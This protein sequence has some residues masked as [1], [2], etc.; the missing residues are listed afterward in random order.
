MKA[1]IFFTF[2]YLFLIVVLLLLSCNGENGQLSGQNIRYPIDSTG[3]ATEAWQMDSLMALINQKY[4]RERN[5]ILFVQNIEKTENWRIAICPHDDYAYA[6]ELYPYVLE[7]LKTPTVIIF[8]VAHKAAQ[9]GIEDHLVFDSFSHWQGPYGPVPVSKLRENLLSRLP[10][11]QYIIH[12]SLQQNEH[13]VEALIPFL[14]YYQPAVE[15]IPIL[16]P[17]MNFDRMEKISGTLSTALKEMSNDLSLKWGKDFS[18]V[19]SNDCVHYGDTGWNGKDYAPFGADT[20]G[21][22][23]A[24]NYDM[25]I[26]SECLIDQLEPQRIK[27]FFEYTVDIN[28]Y[29]KYAWTWCGRYSIPVGLL[30]A[31]YLQ[32]SFSSQPLEGRM[33]R[34]GTSISR[35]AL[36]VEAYGMGKTA[37][38]HI[39]HW[40]GYVALGYMP[41]EY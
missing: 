33:L 12:D 37:P 38:A 34:Y 2:I 1:R 18:L 35:P 11:D 21:Y 31:Y 15:I 17:T 3:Y 4:G 23:A 9:F 16:V 27:R 40:V 24:T 5:N 41:P 25:N 28:N 32:K 22:R 36:D 26:I 30:T 19:I 6:G 20:A 29:R 14:Q 10:D 39:H 8:G 7:N 13:S